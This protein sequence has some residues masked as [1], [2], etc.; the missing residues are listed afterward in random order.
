MCG[1][2]HATSN[3]TSNTFYGRH[4]ISV[5]QVRMSLV[6][7]MICGT[8]VTSGNKAEIFSVDVL[9]LEITGLPSTFFVFFYGFSI[10]NKIYLIE[11]I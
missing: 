11:V 9:L 6:S 8:F 7:S 10:I 2:S 5:I 4:L 1:Y 3:D